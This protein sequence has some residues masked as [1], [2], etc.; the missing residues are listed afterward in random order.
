MIKLRDKIEIIKD[1]LEQN[2]IFDS[3]EIDWILVSVLGVSRS[4]LNAVKEI[5]PEQSCKI[6]EILKKRAKRIPLDKILGKTNFYGLDFIVNRDVL[7]PRFET[8]VLCETVIKVIKKGFGLDLCTG[9]GAI[10]VTLAK[11]GFSM[12]GVDIS[13]R[14]LEIARKN[15]KN[16]KAEVVFKKSNLFKN[17]KNVQYDFIVSNPPYIK[18]GDIKNLKDEVKKYDPKIALDGGRDGL[19][20][21]RNITNDAPRFLK[22]GGYLFFEIGKDSYSDIKR[23]ML[24]D[25]ESI[26]LV[27][28]LD[29][30]IRI[31]YGRLKK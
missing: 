19:F 10:A 31:I 8:E 13:G 7:L 28:D 1:S 25:F 6:D 30:I 29:G 20:F 9:S 22:P 17:L 12:E 11:H 5:T 16:N 14:A 26:K 2:G 23:M 27:H 21:Y 4:G 15:A 24:K 18:T 3:S